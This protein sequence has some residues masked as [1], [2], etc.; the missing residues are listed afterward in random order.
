M[1]LYIH[2][3]SAVDDMILTNASRTNDGESLRF[4]FSGY[5]SGSIRKH[6][7]LHNVTVFP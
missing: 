5:N 1:N 3:H 7:K 4:F 6:Y 2:I